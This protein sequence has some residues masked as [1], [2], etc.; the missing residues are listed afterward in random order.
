MSSNK[1]NEVSLDTGSSAA[2]SRAIDTLE[3]IKMPQ[4]PEIPAGVLRLA[5]LMAPAVRAL[6]PFN[7]AIKNAT[8]LTKVPNISED[9]IGADLRAF[10]ALLRYL[11]QASNDP[12]IK[13]SEIVAKI[14]VEI[15]HA[16]GELDIS[17]ARSQ[18]EIAKAFALPS[19]SAV[20]SKNA[21]GRKR[22]DGFNAA[23]ELCKKWFANP[24]LYKNKAAFLR[25]VVAKEWCADQATAG[26]WLTVFIED[27]QP[28]DRWLAKF[29]KYVKATL[30]TGNSGA[31]HR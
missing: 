13:K 19:R 16:L 1:T 20:N 5:E 11:D 25:D 9:L 14:V 30:T 27:L 6:Q 3:K 15:N 29:P 8:G 28:G 17:A 12:E 22:K 10:I 21:K 2:V 4:M 18:K 7:E 24:D 26:Q 23:E 31:S